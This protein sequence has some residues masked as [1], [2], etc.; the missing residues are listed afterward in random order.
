[1]KISNFHI[2]AVGDAP[3][4]TLPGPDGTGFFTGANGKTG[5]ISDLLSK[6]GVDVINLV[7]IA[8]GLLFFFNLI[9]AGWDYMLSSGDPKKA[10]VASARFTNGLTGLVMAIT[11]FLVVKIFSTM[12]GFSTGF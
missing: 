5:T 4:S 3:I 9:L 8:V 6:G 7:F 12:L 10:A 2:N 11:A 1:M